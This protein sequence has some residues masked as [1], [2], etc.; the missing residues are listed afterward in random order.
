MMTA[1]TARSRNPALRPAGF[2]AEPE[3]AAFLVQHQEAMF[4]WALAHAG[5]PLDTRN[6]LARRAF[7]ESAPGTGQR[8][9][10]TRYASWLFGAMLLVAHRRAPEGG[11][12]EDM[13]GGLPPELR[14]LLRL[15]GRAEMSP[16]EA[17]GLLREPMVTV[18]ER[19]LKA[20]IGAFSRGEHQHH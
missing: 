13:L 16:I 17:W 18:R 19:L 5:G 11:L 4:R 7:A 8:Q 9:D 15:V 20:R 14:S 1:A 3:F 10:H 2:G 6:P 12:G